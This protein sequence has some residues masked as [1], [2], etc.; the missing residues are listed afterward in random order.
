MVNPK[1]SVIIPTYNRKGLLGECLESL[2]NQTYPRENYEIIVVD[3]GS[4]D[5]TGETLKDIQASHGNFR[6]FK[7]ENMG[8]AAARNLGAANSQGEIMAFIN[9]DGRAP[10]DLL[11]KIEAC[12]RKHAEISA[13]VGNSIPV[14]KSGLLGGLGEYFKKRYARDLILSGLSFNRSLDSNCLG[15]RRADFKD[16]GGFDGSFA[17][18]GEDADFE[19]RLLK[20]GKKI[21]VSKDIFVFHVQRDAVSKLVVKA[22]RLGI[23]DT[24]VFRDHFSNWLVVFLPFGRTVSLK[25]FPFTACIS[26]DH[27]KIIALMLVSA[28]FSPVLSLAM[29]AAYAAFGCVKTGGIKLFLQL[30]LYRIIIYTGYLTGR[31]TESIQ[32]GVFFV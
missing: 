19:C 31:I 6:Y 26:F 3:D 28:L 9:D 16:I 21:L 7:Q 20:N 18:A 23:A 1:I 5:G 32:N 11:E 14:F 27:L 17:W 2:F 24:R 8:P 15:V 29:I 25:K 13:C 30:T 4:S 22:H 10:K 12:M